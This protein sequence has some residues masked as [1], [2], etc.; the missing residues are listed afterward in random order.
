MLSKYSF[1][2]WNRTI[3]VVLLSSLA[4]IPVSQAAAPATAHS[5]CH[6]INGKWV[7]TWESFY[8]YHCTWNVSADAARYGNNNVSMKVVAYNGNPYGQCA[9]NSTFFLSGSCIDGR[10]ILNY[11]SGSGYG[12]L[13][14]SIFSGLVQMGNNNNRAVL[15]KIG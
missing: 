5:S 8:P 11:G 12:T 2:K 10:L 9:N 15:N 6:N 14:G 3:L 7:G 1:K 4:Y 13:D